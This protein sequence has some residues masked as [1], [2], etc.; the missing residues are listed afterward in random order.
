M[1]KKIEET[2]KLNK[3]AIEVLTDVYLVNNNKMLVDLIMLMKSIKNYKKMLKHTKDDHKE[4]LK[5][6]TSW[7]KTSSDSEKMLDTD[8]M[9]EYFDENET[10]ICRL[11]SIKNKMNKADSLKAELKKYIICLESIEILILRCVNDEGKMK[12]VDVM[13]N[14]LKNLHKYS[15][16]HTTSIYTH[17]WN[18]NSDFDE[19]ISNVNNNLTTHINDLEGYVNTLKAN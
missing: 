8:K 10:E 1:N 6:R 5:I 11:I 13:S 14:L 9:C 3:P 16:I 7:M 2:S 12:Y 4:K 19:I 17:M 15:H 18:I